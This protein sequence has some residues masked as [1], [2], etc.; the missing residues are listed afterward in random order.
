MNLS[1]V[2]PVSGNDIDRYSSLLELLHCLEGQSTKPK[3]V[4]IIEQCLNDNGAGS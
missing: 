1:V 2:I 3:E 4:L